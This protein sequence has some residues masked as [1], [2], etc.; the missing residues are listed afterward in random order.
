MSA[1][2]LKL[3]RFRQNIEDAEPALQEM[4]EYQVEVINARQ[5]KG[6]GSPEVGGSWAP[7]SPPYKRFKDRVRPGRPILVFD[8]DLRDSMTKVPSGVF[9]VT[10]KSF[11]V[12]T[13]VHY[14]T[15]HQNGTPTMPARPLL[16]SPR[17]RDTQHFVK[18]LQRHIVEGTIA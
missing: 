5:F 14:A 7:L 11:T 16:G 17:K 15:Y 8:G 3:D 10:H 4:A 1:F 13:Q 18:I 6:Q 12:G 9:E 2:A